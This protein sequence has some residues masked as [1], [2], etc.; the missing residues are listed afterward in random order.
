MGKRHVEGAPIACKQTI[1]E[2]LE[3]AVDAA[4]LVSRSPHES[5]RHHRPE[6]ERNAGRHCDRGGDGEGEFAEQPVD[7][8]AHQQQRNEHGNEGDADR[9]D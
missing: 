2:R 8:A 4:V 5:C 7:N 3:C 9:Q 6:R 1:E